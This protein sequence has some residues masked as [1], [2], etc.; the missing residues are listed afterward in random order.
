MQSF[1]TELE[2]PIVEKDILDL[3][4]KIQMFKEGKIDDDKF[5]SLRLARGVYGQR[6]EGVQMIRIK[7]PY[8]K[9]TFDQWRRICTVSDEYSTG[10]MHFTTRQDIQIHYVSL[11]RTP[12]LW[13]ELEKDNVTLREACGN[14]VRNVTGSVTSGVDKAE[15]FDLTSHA[16][17]TFEYFLRNPICQEMGRKMKF[18]FS[19]TDEDTALA[20]MHDIGFIA[21]VKD[22]Q[23]GFKVV[24]GGGLGAQ[25]RMADVAYEFL[26]ENMIIP[27]AESILRVFDRHGERNSRSKARMKFLLAKIGFEAFMELLEEERAA[28]K[29]KV[30]EINTT[31]D[32]P[33]LAYKIA[34][35]NVEITDAKKH[36]NWKATN[37]IEQK[38]EGLFGVFVRVPLG[39]ITTTETRN[40]LDALEGY[41]GND[42]RISINQGLFFRNIPEANL[43]YVY[44][45]LAKFGYAE[46]GA[47]SVVN[48][49]AC[50]GTDTCN[51]AISD[52]T[53]ITKVLEGVIESEFPE[54][55]KN[56]DILIKISGCM[57]SCGQHG[58]AN[59]GFHGS[60]MRTKDKRVL[61]ALQVL[62]GG[63]TIGD[64]EGRAADKVI[65]VPSKKGPDVLRYVLKDYAEN[66]TEGER[67][68]DYYDR[69]G[70]IY[71]YDILKPLADITTLVETD[72]IDWGREEQFKTEI[73]VGECASVI[74]DLVGILFFESEEKLDNA[75]AAIEEK[76]Y[77]DAIY[78]TYSSQVN[79][80]KGL[81]IDKGVKTNTQ[82]SVIAG[83]DENYKEE[84]GGLVAEQI[85]QINKNEPSLEFAN[86]YLA[87]GKAFLEK[88]MTYRNAQNLK[89]A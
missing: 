87:E 53:A 55:I 54:L 25:P 68:N 1:R 66:A 76:R 23:R 78:H 77:A 64:G 40:L 13:A 16:H 27:L 50:P 20:Y 89:L 59:I 81:L 7:L 71:F 21:K 12:E 26:P 33:E 61:P 45:V 79:A 11:D 56:N 2:N 83:F 32:A 35:G 30:Y 44:S 3:G 85:L 74:V 15:P 57:N 6:Q 86:K 67:F 80:A 82:M 14:T 37:V 49:T 4:R 69:Q 70:K 17:A 42:M 52:S 46:A 43:D 24:V 9:M 38:Q 51:L 34:E 31:T 19:N 36:E 18:S 88:A 72:F 65:K 47:N 29:S 28:L 84:F 63:G 73:G 8:G 75:Q 22:G 48:I 60:S 58:V 10:M 39:N 41:I 5:R 62:L